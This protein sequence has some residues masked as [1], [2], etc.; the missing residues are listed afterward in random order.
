MARPS[1]DTPIIIRKKKVM[2]HA[3]HGGAW[4]VAFADFMTAMFAL[5]LV[6]W[7]VNQSA[8]V[9]DAIANYFRDPI[10]FEQGGNLQ[11]SIGGADSP[12][13]DRQV[14]DPVAVQRRRAALGTA[15]ERIRRALAASPALARV[16]SNVEVEMTP[17]GLRIAIT[18][19]EGANFFESGSPRL[20]PRAEEVLAVVAQELA[21]LA[22]AL[23]VEGHTDARPLRRGDGYSNWELSTDR[24][25]QARR[26][27][28]A[29]GLDEARIAQ[30]RGFA[31]RDLLE[32]DAPMSPR[33]RRITITVLDEMAAAHA[34]PAEATTTPASATPTTA[35]PAAA[36]VVEE[37]KP[38]EADAGPSARAEDAG[39][40]AAAVADGGAT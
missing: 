22:N 10:G 12:R 19:D 7:L 11:L 15:G 1:R 2:G 32:P 16:A 6:L 3:H 28:V 38:E 36:V 4:K 18:E 5:F 33:N 29:S 35:T 17:E 30:V 26:L 20:E 23:L 21:P 14:Q 37:P 27:L 39:E 8:D 24:A 25:H 9:K 40:H 34:G 13:A 31:D